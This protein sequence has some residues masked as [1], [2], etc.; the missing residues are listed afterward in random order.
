MAPQRCAIAGA[1]AIACARLQVGHP[2]L[3]QPGAS[4]RI[5]LRCRHQR[6]Q[7]PCA[8]QIREARHRGGLTIANTRCIH[9]RVQ[10]LKPL[11]AVTHTDISG[12][13][14]QALRRLH[15]RASAQRHRHNSRNQSHHGF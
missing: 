14:M 12:L 13:Q 11:R 2:Q 8:A 3:L 6:R 4:Q 15:G 7:K 10:R 1:F 5:R 9:C